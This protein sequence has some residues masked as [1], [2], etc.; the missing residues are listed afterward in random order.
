MDNEAED[1]PEKFKEEERPSEWP[2][3]IQQKHSESS[4]VEQL[5]LPK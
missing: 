1:L 2:D 3:E 5:A 4:C